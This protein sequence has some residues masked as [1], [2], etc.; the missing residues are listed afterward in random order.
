MARYRIKQFRHGPTK[1]CIVGRR[2]LFMWWNIRWY[3]LVDRTFDI[4]D[5][6]HYV[7][8]KRDEKI[9]GKYNINEI[10]V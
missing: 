1:R 7:A 8:V 10:K 9:N 6:Q 2:F 3:H 4:R 5:G